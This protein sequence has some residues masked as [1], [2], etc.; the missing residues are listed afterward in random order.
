MNAIYE[1]SDRGGHD[2]LTLPIPN[3]MYKC[4][5]VQFILSRAAAGLAFGGPGSEFLP[6]PLGHLAAFAAWHGGPSVT[7]PSNNLT[8]HTT[9]THIIDPLM[10]LDYEDQCINTHTHTHIH[11]LL[12]HCR[13]LP[14]RHISGGSTAFVLDVC[15]RGH[16]HLSGE[17]LLPD[18]RDL[19]EPRADRIGS[20]NG[21]R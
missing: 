5:L 21:L 12:C 11:M 1:G 6:F 17:A 10:P 14:P 15:Q 3:V 2:A 16:S 8:R 20:D 7:Y 13:N 9:H 4:L 19:G 18:V